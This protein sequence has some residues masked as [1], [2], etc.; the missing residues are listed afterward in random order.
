LFPDLVY[1][2]KHALT[3]EVAY[4][5]L[6][7]AQRRGLHAHLVEAPEAPAR[8]QVV[9]PGGR[10]APPP[11]QGGGGGKAVGECRQGGLKMFT[12]AA[13]REAVARFEE[14]LMAHTHLPDGRDTREQAIDLRF[15][16][17][18][19]LWPLAEFGQLLNHLRAAERLAESLQDQRRLAWVLSHM[20]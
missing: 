20:T 7:H 16:L 5:S 3:Q 8:G 19:A 17:R 11:Q 1:T 13:Y 12:R 18:K 14:G 10:P 2:F 15:D 9:A 4:G 6:L